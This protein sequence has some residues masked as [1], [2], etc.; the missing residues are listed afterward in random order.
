MK[1]YCVAYERKTTLA[2]T[3]LSLESENTPT[4]FL[5][6][7]MAEVKLSAPQNIIGKPQINSFQHFS[8]FVCVTQRTNHP[9]KYLTC[10]KRPAIITVTF[11]NF[12]EI[13]YVSFS[14]ITLLSHHN[15]CS[16]RLSVSLLLQKTIMDFK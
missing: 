1:L 6:F 10:S 15:Y 11:M 7:R 13:Q 3:Q 2:Q 8:V 16:E 5:A 12:I 9:S 4:I 14:N